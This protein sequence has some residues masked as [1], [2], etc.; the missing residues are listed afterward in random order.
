MNPCTDKRENVHVEE[1]NNAP[2]KKG[3]H[4]EPV[5]FLKLIY[6]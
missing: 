4:V 5:I 1:N 2:F 6:F 3:A